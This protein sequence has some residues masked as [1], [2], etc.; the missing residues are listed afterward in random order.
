MIVIMMSVALFNV[1][2][3]CAINQE[4]RASNY[5]VRHEAYFLAATVVSLA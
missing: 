2:S 5:P 4:V 3:V 1:L